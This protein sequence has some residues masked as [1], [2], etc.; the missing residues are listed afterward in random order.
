MNE[1]LAPKTIMSVEVKHPEQLLQSARFGVTP[2]IE[3][4]L[5]YG[6]DVNT[7]TNLGETPLHLASENGHLDSMWK[8]VQSRACVNVVDLNGVTPLMLAAQNGH[9]FGVEM[10]VFA[11]AVVNQK[12]DNGN[13]AM[14]LAAKNGQYDC[15]KLLFNAGASVNAV[16]NFHATAMTEAFFNGHNKCVCLLEECEEEIEHEPRSESRLN[17]VNASYETIDAVN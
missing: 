1:H 12:E 9:M 10:L 17:R 15:I 6:E 2:L 7:R 14:I 4:L 8:L 5:K 13:T 16:N 3:S 11:G